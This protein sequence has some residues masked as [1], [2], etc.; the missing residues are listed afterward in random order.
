MKRS[1]QLH[2]MIHYEA[3]SVE[4]GGLIDV[5]CLYLGRQL[6]RKLVNQEANEANSKT[7]KFAETHVH[8]SR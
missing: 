6:L 2:F 7:G 5:R 4:N 1:S 8:S 3:S